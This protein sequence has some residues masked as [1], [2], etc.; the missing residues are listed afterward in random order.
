MAASFLF[1]EDIHLG[2]ELR[3]RGDGTGLGKHLT[4]LDVLALNTTE[5]KSDVVS[6]HTFVEKLVEHFHTRDDGLAGLADTDDLDFFVDLHLTLLD[7]A[8]S[9]RTATLN[10]EDV[11]DGHEERLVCLALWIG[12]VGI[13]SLKEILELLDVSSVSLDCLESGT[14]DDWRLVAGEFVLREKLSDLYFHEIKKLRVCDHVDFVEEDDDVR[15]SDLASEKNVLASLWHWSVCCRDNEDGS[16]HLGGTGDHVFHVVGV[17]WT[18]DVRIVA[19]RGLVLNVRSVDGD[20]ALALLRSVVDICVSL[21]LAFRREIHG[22]GCSQ[23]R[24]TVVDVT[25]GTD[26]NVRL[27][28]IKLLLVCHGSEREWR[29]RGQRAAKSQDSVGKGFMVRQLDFF[30]GMTFCGKIFR[31]PF[32]CMGKTTCNDELQAVLVLD[33]YESTMLFY[34]IL[35][36]AWWCTRHGDLRGSSHATFSFLLTLVVPLLFLHTGGMNKSDRIQAF[37]EIIWQWYSQ[38]K[39]TLPWR[40]LPDTD[41]AERAYKVMVSEIMLQQTQVSRVKIVF[42]NFLE[43]FPCIQDLAQASNR[44]VLL[45]WRGMG[46]NSRALRLR[47]AA[48]QIVT[49]YELRVASS[50]TSN[51]QH[52]TIYFPSSMKELQVISGI[53]PYTAAAI[54]NFAFNFPTPCIDTNIRRILHRTFVG[55]EHP[56]GA[57]TKDDGFLLKLAEEILD[58]AIAGSVQ[59]RDAANWHAALMDFGSLVQTKRNPRWDIC[60]LTTNGIMKTTLATFKKMQTRNPQ[61]ATHNSVVEPGRFVG[62]KYIPNRI[63]RGKVIEE[64][65]DAPKGLPLETIGSRICLDW[66]PRSHRTWLQGILLRLKRDRL[67]AEERGSYVLAE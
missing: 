30:K 4:A 22:K 1:R 19:L 33:P 7:A 55:P 57:W 23:C 47:D 62:S 64:L 53:G 56:D 21:L 42:K 13:E 59:K 3:V 48:R 28:A 34:D 6:S 46:Y 12:D 40:D 8:G 10:G 9:N 2:I 17:S 61:P 43:I 58:V 41:P 52:E 27:R 35:G 11:L 54:R 38:N 49:S 24:L 15:Y 36:R 67:V 63:F 20:T 32:L 14:A 25:D 66:S 39:R 26:V 18:V 37:V 45:A 29:S 50:P 44:D 65:R 5:E 31:F 51:Q 16:V 60:P